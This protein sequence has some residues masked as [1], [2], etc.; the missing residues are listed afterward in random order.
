MEIFDYT[1]AEHG[2]NQAVKYLSDLDNLFEQL[3]KNPNL[4]KERKEIKKGIYSIVEQEHIIFYE[5][6]EEFILI[7]RVFTVVEGI[8]LNLSNNQIE[9]ICNGNVLSK[10]IPSCNQSIRRIDK[11]CR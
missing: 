6:Q 2:F 8:F 4:G 10:T 9:S 1:E 11:S 7:T 3:V 5:I